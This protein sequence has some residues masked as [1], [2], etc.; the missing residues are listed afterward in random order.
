M[1][2]HKAPHSFL[3]PEK[4][5]ENAFD[6]VR[7]RTRKAFQLDDKPEWIK[8]RLVTWH[9]IY[10]PLFDWRKDFPDTSAAGMLDFE[11]M[12]RAYRGTIL[13]VDDSVGRI[14]EYLKKPA[15]W[16]TRCSSSPATTDCSRRARDG[17]QAD[18]PRGRCGFRWWCAIPD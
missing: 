4:K 2:G 9:G 1:L 14:Y 6:H 5:Y 13:S 3:F 8:K 10:G 15:S 7:F 16:T 18:R 12:V 11:N 17:R